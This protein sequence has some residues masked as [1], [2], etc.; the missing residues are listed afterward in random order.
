MQS[1]PGHWARLFTD[2]NQTLLAYARRRAPF[3]E[4]AADAVAETYARA[5]AACS[6]GRFQGDGPTVG[7]LIGILRN[8]LREQARRRRER[9][10]GLLDSGP[11]AGAEVDAAVLAAEEAD[12][13]RVALTRLADG[14][15]ALVVLRVVEGRA[16]AEVADLTG[17][18][19][20][21]VRVAQTRA[22]RRL[23]TLLAG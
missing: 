21:G 6:A 20:A 5:L 16:S 14:E 7:W 11:A 12:Q 23:G 9:P 15:R 2:T 19:A 10:A 4:D 18:S 3:R 1:E 13:V 8:V 17:R 22:L